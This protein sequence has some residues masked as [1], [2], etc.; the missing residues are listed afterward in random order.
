[1]SKDGKDKFR[2]ENQENLDSVFNYLS[3]LNKGL[4]HRHLSF[5]KDDDLVDVILPDDVV[6]SIEADTAK[7]EGSLRIQLK[8]TAVESA[9]DD[10]DKAEKKRLKGEQKAAEKAEKKRLKVEREAAEE[11]AKAAKKLRKA[12]EKAKKEEE[13]ARRKVTEQETDPSGGVAEQASPVA[14]NQQV[15]AGSTQHPRPQKKPKKAKAKTA[16]NPDARRA[17]R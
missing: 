16:T 6:M 10:H 12:E 3:M 5:G 11:A 15:D 1:M 7:G 9:D 17:T 14:S 13:K 8:W 4:K 2:Y